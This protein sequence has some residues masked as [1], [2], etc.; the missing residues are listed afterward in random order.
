MLSKAITPKFL[1]KKRKTMTTIG[2]LRRI[3]VEICDTINRL[4]P[5]FI[6]HVTTLSYKINVLEI[7]MF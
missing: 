2:R 1:A 4:N 5:I 3:Y 6:T 7:N